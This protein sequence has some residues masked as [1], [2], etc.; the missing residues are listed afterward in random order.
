MERND[1]DED[2]HHFDQI[3]IA[4]MTYLEDN[5][6][7]PI[8]S[9]HH[10]RH[11]SSLEDATEDFV[12][13]KQPPTDTSELE[14]DSDG[15]SRTKLRPDDMLFP[16]S[17]SCAREG[18]SRC[19]SRKRIAETQKSSKSVLTVVIAVYSTLMSGFF[20]LL[21]LLQ[22]RYGTHVSTYGALTPSMVALI[23]A[24][25]AKTIEVSYVT[26][27]VSYLG[28]VISRRAVLQSSTSGFTLADLGMR[29]WLM[30]PGSL[31]SHM[32]CVRFAAL[33]TMGAA[34]IGGALASLLY[35]TA[36]NVLVQPQI[37]THVLDKVLEGSVRTPFA[38]SEYIRLNCK[39]PEGLGRSSESFSDCLTVL[40][41][42]QGYHSYQRYL[43]AWSDLLGNKTMPTQKSR[44]TLPAQAM[45]FASLNENVSIIATWISDTYYDQHLPGRANGLAVST[46][47]LGMPHP[48]VPQ[49]AIDPRQKIVQPRDLGQLGSYSVRASVP[50]PFLQITCA[51][52]TGA[53][54]S[55]LIFATWPRSAEEHESF[56]SD[57]GNFEF[58]PDTDWAQFA[59][60]NRTVLGDL[61]EWG[62][63]NVPPVFETWPRP[64]HA[65]TNYT[66]FYSDRRTVYILGNL[67]GNDDVNNL[68]RGNFTLCS[69]NAGLSARCS[70]RF[71]CSASASTLEALC[72]D[73]DD[74]LAYH[75]SSNQNSPKEYETPWNYTRMFVDVLDAMSLNSYGDTIYLDSGSNTSIASLFLQT[76]HTTSEM[77]KLMSPAEALAIMAGHS[78]VMASVDTPFVKYWN[79]TQIYNGSISQAI[80][81]NGV[82]QWFNT[83]VTAQ[84]YA[85]GGVYPY[86]RLF[87]IVLIY[88]FITN[89]LMLV[90]FIRNPGRITDFS[91]P[92]NLFAVAMNS[93]PGERIAGSCGGGPEG[94]EYRVIWNVN[95]HEGHVFLEAA[96]QLRGVMGA[97]ADAGTPD[98]ELEETNET[99]RKRRRWFHP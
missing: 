67:P 49:A 59:I 87:N 33:S 41:T 1:M 81:A 95:Q 86:Q 64:N 46:V 89:V 38:N 97:R 8:S 65:A 39:I 66:P 23:T 31:I 82:S 72:D 51:E 56:Q 88:V 78:L 3:D 20:M 5:G 76:A 43:A 84:E 85:S 26:V 53:D 44:P 37:K 58:N 18:S 68:S 34:A 16:P 6:G 19:Q 17:S 54:I 99:V 29:S 9:G 92:P 2:S 15:G 79:Y 47:M 70:T 73:P 83:S 94:D 90:Y 57:F 55:P 96:D 74:K 36:A 12:P 7:L 63:D 77:E 45:S 35:T 61:F 48:G 10:L 71:N 24:V 75:V 52:V 25:L 80:Q 14:G 21:A 27:F 98:M 11:H 60:S 28:Q 42:S 91:D 69:F 13:G 22:P 40:Q 50:S 4:P 93:P 62:I 30:Q 32:E